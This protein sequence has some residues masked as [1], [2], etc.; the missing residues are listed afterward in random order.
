VRERLKTLYG[1]TAGLQLTQ[2]AGGGT[3]ATLWLPIQD[4]SA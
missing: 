4:T 3:L 1:E 2:A